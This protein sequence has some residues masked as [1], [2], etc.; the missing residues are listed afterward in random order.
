MPLFLTP[1]LQ[2]VT[3]DLDPA[4]V[5]AAKQNVA[6]NGC[7]LEQVVNESRAHLIMVFV[8]HKIDI[9]VVFV[10]RPLCFLI[11]IVKFRL[12]FR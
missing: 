9:Y 1:Y 5:V 3:N 8:F 2:V 10:F 4:A 7:T 12:F 11:L 6:F